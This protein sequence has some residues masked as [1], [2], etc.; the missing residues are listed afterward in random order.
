MM[1]RLIS[2]GFPTLGMVQLDPCRER[3]SPSC[4]NLSITTSND[5][6]KLSDFKTLHLVTICD[7]VSGL[8]VRVVLRIKGNVGLTVQMV[9]Y[10]LFDML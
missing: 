3:L 1:A 4:S 8:P 10:P 7:V 9:A 5:N 2:R 6:L